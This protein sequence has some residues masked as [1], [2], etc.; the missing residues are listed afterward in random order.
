MRIF[1]LATATAEQTRAGKSV[2]EVYFEAQGAGLERNVN[3]PVTLPES[4]R[5]PSPCSSR[6]V[7]WG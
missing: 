3:D 2:A 1:D 7:R 6:M 5:T 4:I